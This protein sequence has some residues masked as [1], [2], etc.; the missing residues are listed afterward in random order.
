MEVAMFSLNSYLSS[1]KTGEVYSDGCY[2][3]LALS[4]PEKNIQLT[5]YL[6]TDEDFRV[7]C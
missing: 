4:K 6:L 3:L 5:L 1:N 2:L 7:V